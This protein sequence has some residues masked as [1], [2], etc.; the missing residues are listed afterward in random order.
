[1]SSISAIDH[2]EA[3]IDGDTVVPGMN[4]VLPAG[5]GSTQYFNPSTGVCTPDYTKAA[6]QILLYPACYSSLKGKYLVPDAGSVQWYFDNPD[7]AGAQILAAPGGSVAD[8]YKTRFAVASYKVNN[9]TFPALKVI[10]NLASKESLNDVV[11]YCRFTSGGMDITC[12]CPIGIRVSVGSLF[13]ILIVSLNEQGV[14]DTVIDNDSEYLLLTASLQDSGVDVAASG[15][16]SWQ[17]ATADGLAAVKNVPGVTEITGGGKTLKLFDLAIE[18]TEE[19]FAEVVHNGQTYRKGIQVSD[20]HDPFYINLGRST[21]GNL[22]RDTDTITY[23]PSVLARSSGKQ[24]TGWTFTYTLRDNLGETIRTASGATCKV[25][26][27]EVRA[28]GGILMHITAG[29]A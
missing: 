21:P 17:R 28:A 18:G 26:G 6:N 7:A 2:L 14:N 27:E 12:H 23:T 3:I 15:A 9:Q 19:Y 20:T 11:L 29:K 8:A 13:D 5:V 25:T 10:G 16:W 24:Q 1:M 22:V 4:L